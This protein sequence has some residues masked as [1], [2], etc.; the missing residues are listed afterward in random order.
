MQEDMESI[1]ND[2]Q[3]AQC[4]VAAAPVRKEASHKSE[5]VN[6]LVYGEP[7]EMLDEKDEWRFIKSFYDG[8]EGWVTF[9]LIKKAQENVASIESYDLTTDIFT[10]WTVGNGSNIYLPMG[11][12]LKKGGENN[13]PLEADKHTSLFADRLIETAK[14]WLHVPYLWGGKT[15]MGVDCSGFVQTVF[16][17]YGIVLKRDAYQQAEQGF[18]VILE[19]AEMGDV[20]FFNNEAGRITHVGILLN[21][22]EIIHAAGKVRIDSLDR[23][24]IQNAELKKQTHH[25][26]SVRR[27]IS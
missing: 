19:N 4:D 17:V 16:K 3:Y 22:N 6:Q 2:K 11:S 14:K 1:K 10:E 26:H 18:E 12:F 15:A 23:K 8:Y 21:Q 27:M 7:L 20:A 24:G 9:H 13:K 5:M 25:F